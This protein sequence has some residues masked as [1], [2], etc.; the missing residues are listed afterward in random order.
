MLH[1][2]YVQQK[3]LQSIS[4]NKNQQWISAHGN[5]QWL[6]SKHDFIVCDDQLHRNKL[7]KLIKQLNQPPVQIKIHAKII[8]MDKNKNIKKK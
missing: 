8:S 2:M 7:E 1:L 3:D 5:T 6:A 4:A